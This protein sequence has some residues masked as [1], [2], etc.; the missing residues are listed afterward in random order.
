MPITYR[1]EKGSPLTNLEVDDNFRD[2]DQRATANQQ[3]ASSAAAAASVADGK[4][5]DAQQAASNA[6]SAADA[7]GQLAA[8]AGN[9]AVA[10]QQAAGTADNKAQAAQ[11]TADAAK[12]LAERAVPDTRPETDQY[13][14]SIYDEA[15][16]VALGV[17]L[18][19]NVIAAGVGIADLKATA[20]E[21]KSVADVA[22]KSQK[23]EYGKFVGGVVDDFGGAPIRFD[24]QGGSHIYEVV[25]DASQSEGSGVP[26]VVGPDI[27]RFVSDEVGTVALGF[28]RTTGRAIGDFG[29]PTPD[30]VEP[31]YS[32]DLSFTRVIGTPE[33]S[34]LTV[35]MSGVTLRYMGTETSLSNVTLDAASVGTGL[36]F[37]DFVLT[38]RPGLTYPATAAMPLLDANWLEWAHVVVAE[39]RRASDSVALAAGVDYTWHD[40]GKLG[41]MVDTADYAVNVT[42]SG[43][44]E[45]YDAICWNMETQS[46]VVRQGVERPVTAHEDLYRGRPL[47]GDIHLFNAWVV[48]GEIAE[49]IPTWEWNQTQHRFLGDRYLSIIDRGRRALAKTRSKLQRGEGIII[50]GYGDSN[51]AIGGGTYGGPADL[52]PN[53]P[54]V[55]TGPYGGPFYG[56]S[57][58]EADFRAA[59]EASIE[60]VVVNG[61]SRFKSGPNWHVI[62]AIQN[63]YGYTF[64]PDVI[65]ADG[66]IFYLNH[67]IGGSSHQS[68]EGNG[69]HPDRL[70]ALLNP[71][72]FRTPDVVV[73]AF[74]MNLGQS[75][76]IVPDMA[77]IITTIKAAGADVV[78][79]GPHWTNQQG[80]R[81]TLAAWRT[82]HRRLAAVAEYCG[83]AYVPMELSLAAEYRGYLGISDYSVTRAN[84][85]N[86]PGP[87]ERRK[88]GEFIAQFFI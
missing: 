50:S 65:P 34:G 32:G 54:G 35:N 75:A 6:A 66:Q 69:A 88:F 59:Y 61:V 53:R 21:A 81:Y 86:H 1:L 17:T 4:A 55:D 39:V 8:S 58:A 13:A 25:F 80:V 5:V 36:V 20:D 45:R 82:V 38:Y 26:D 44:R 76:D 49:L 64:T 27:V 43:K 23:G 77:T 63:A 51:T 83:A 71:Q 40:N 29:A 11:A 31:D 72:G 30:P 24:E 87:Y 37:D 73:V 60:S 68:S 62:S 18:S 15:G 70:A 10:A 46:L 74:G 2:L 47:N 19:G 7:A 12:S 85:Y 41:G 79:V 28:D 56:T 52:L 14:L 84:W 42:F 48:G 16:L 57:L 22:V 67:G 33:I 9:A 3:A 78:V